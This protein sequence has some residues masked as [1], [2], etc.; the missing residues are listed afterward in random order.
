MH[1]SGWQRQMFGNAFGRDRDD[2][3]VRRSQGLESRR[4]SALRR[5]KIGD[6]SREHGKDLQQ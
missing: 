1:L 3:A 6:E 5:S 4:A 2:N